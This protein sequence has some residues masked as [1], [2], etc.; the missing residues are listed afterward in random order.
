M[1]SVQG[2]TIDEERIARETQYHPANSLDA[3]RGAAARALVVRE[4][5]LHEA[6]QRG[7]ETAD[8]DTRI[9]VLLADQVAASV[10][11]EA[12]CRRYFA[13]NRDRFTSPVRVEAQHILLAAAPDDG[14]ARVAARDRA[15]ALIAELQA[16]PGRF[17]EL[18]REH[19]RCPSKDDGGR[20]GLIG[21]GQTVPELDG[22]LFRLPANTLCAHPVETRYGYHVLRTGERQGGEP[23][24]F[25]AVRERIADYLR[26]QNWRQAV[27]EYLHR[28]IAEARI[29]G[30]DMDGADAPLIQ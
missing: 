11:D 25:D 2:R 4:L 20:L 21:P 9:E 28:L 8:E 17:A 5:L 27:S 18:A 6:E 22:T 3:A 24:P 14:D 16:A 12:A 26:E 10:P 7:I 30:I 13:Q 1:I 29:E 15:E 23:L 19:S